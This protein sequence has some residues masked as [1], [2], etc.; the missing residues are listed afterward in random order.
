M[1]DFLERELHQGD[2]VVV[3][4]EGKLIKGRV[5]RLTY[6]SLSQSWIAYVKLDMFGEPVNSF[7]SPQIVKYQL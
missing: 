3:V 4:I 2:T 1:R 7:K 6:H 5:S